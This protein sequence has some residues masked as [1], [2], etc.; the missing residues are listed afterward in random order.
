LLLAFLKPFLAEGFEGWAA[1]GFFGEGATEKNLPIPTLL[2]IF[3]AQ[4]NLM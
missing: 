2:E 1:V 3:R 4:K